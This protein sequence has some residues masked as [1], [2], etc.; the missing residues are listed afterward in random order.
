MGAGH[1]IVTGK[2][3]L[4]ARIRDITGGK[5]VN[6]AFDPVGGGLIAQYAPALAKNA[7]IYFYG[8]LDTVWPPLPFVDM[9]QKNAVFHPY[10]LFNYVEDPLMC[11]RGKAFV[12]EMLA[13]GRL[14]PS[15]DRVYP[16]EKY[17][18]A[19]DYLSQPRTAHGKVVIE[20]GL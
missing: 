17:I 1:V 8:T 13:A 4:A 3:D 5:G 9:F 18:E 11:E 7:R 2:E 19:F 16:M 14:K 10:S 15:I 12:Y 6:M 20:T